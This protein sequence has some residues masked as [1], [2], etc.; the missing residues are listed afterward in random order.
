[1]AHQVLI[2]KKATKGLQSV[3]AAEREAVETKIRALADDPRPT[4][5]K[6]LKGSSDTYRIRQG[7][8]RVIY[9][10]ED[11]IK[12]VKVEKVGHRKDIYD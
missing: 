8:Y 9:S 12:I 4:G 1:M 5:C 2:S 10:V 6:K 11:K 3:P 7:D